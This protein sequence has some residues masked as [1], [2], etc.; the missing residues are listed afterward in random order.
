MEDSALGDP[1]GEVDAE[2]AAEAA[3]DA[4]A[5]ALR[6]AGPGEDGAER[7]KGLLSLWKQRFQILGYEIYE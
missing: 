6:D 3:V 5:E 1:S 2:A 7:K 4:A